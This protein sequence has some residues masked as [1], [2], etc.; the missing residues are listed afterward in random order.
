MAC[1]PPQSLD[2]SQYLW[3]IPL[4]SIV[5]VIVNLDEFIS[6]YPLATTALALL[7][8]T[9]LLGWSFG[10]KE[11]R[12]RAAEVILLAGKKTGRDWKT[13]YLGDS[14]WEWVRAGYYER[15]GGLMWGGV[16]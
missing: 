16:C 14:L 9:L 12:R 7:V 11:L 1:I 5:G 6:G 8:A 10:S 2:R 15:A 4:A 3:V 13:L